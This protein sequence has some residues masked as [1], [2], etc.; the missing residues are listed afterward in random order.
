MFSFIIP[1][2]TWWITFP[3]TLVTILSDKKQYTIVWHEPRT[4][5]MPGECKVKL[6]RFHNTKAHIESAGFRVKLIWSWPPNQIDHR[7]RASYWIHCIHFVWSPL[8]T[9]RVS[10]LRKKISIDDCSVQINVAILFLAPPPQVF[11]DSP[12]HIVKPKI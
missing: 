5:N 6:Q 7:L 3:R 1:C 11:I 9:S 2:S 8:P 4:I 10:R 12:V